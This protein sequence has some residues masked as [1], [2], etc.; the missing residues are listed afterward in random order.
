[1]FLGFVY[2]TEEG[3]YGLKNEYYVIIEISLIST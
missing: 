1:M 3:V 2:M